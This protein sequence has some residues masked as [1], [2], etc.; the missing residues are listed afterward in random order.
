MNS[1]PTPVPARRSSQR[2]WIVAGLLALLAA[3]IGH[4]PVV[5]AISPDQL[6]GGFILRE[7]WLRKGAQDWTLR[8]ERKTYDVVLERLPWSIAVLRIRP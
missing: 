6:R 8:V 3:V 1:V 7:G 4:W 5:G 2:I